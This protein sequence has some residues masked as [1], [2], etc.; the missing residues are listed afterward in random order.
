MRSVVHFETVQLPVNVSPFD[1][2]WFSESSS[3]SYFDVPVAL[4]AMMLP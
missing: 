2:R 1:A 3:A 4:N